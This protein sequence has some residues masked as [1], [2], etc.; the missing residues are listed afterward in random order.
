MK[1]AMVSSECVPFAKTGGLADVVG[2]L[3][4]ALRALGHETLV[5]LPRYADIDGG[6]FG[7][8]PYLAP[9]GVWM[10]DGEEWCAVQAATWEGVPFYFI[11]CD[12]Y[13]AR[14]GLYYDLDFHDY[15]D[16]GRRFGFFTRAALQLC[17]D[18]GFA[19]DVVHAHD[20]QTALAPA[21]LKIWHWDD[22]LLGRA[23]SVLTVHNIAHQGKVDAEAYGHLG[24]QAAN[25][26][27]DKFE[28]H[29]RINFLKGGLHYADVANTVS[30]THAVETRGPLGGH[31]LA[32]FLNDLGDRYVGILNGVDYGEWDPAA[33]PRIPARY[34]RDDPAGKAAC[35]S[36]LQR[37]LGLDEDPTV[38]LVGSVGRFADQK[39]MDVVAA[40]IE[41][42][43]RAMRVQYVVL[44]SGEKGLE[45]FY[46]TL[47]GRHPGRIASWIGYH[48]ELAHWIEAG[49]DFFLM[50]SRFEPCGLNQI[51]SLRYGTLPIVRATGGLNDTV[52]QYDEATGA[53]T[54]FKFDLLT[55][56][57]V[58]DVLGWAVSTFY[59]RPRHV[60]R[61]VRE[62]MARDFSWAKSAREYASLY[63]RAIEHQRR[64]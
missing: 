48:D 35:K 36:A 6:R 26:T 51:Y 2:G 13:F 8:V 29:G 57:A 10:G 5:V 1:V 56:R 61:M 40:A 28:D 24:L 18:L 34:T 47:P 54:G 62:A 25:F 14:P 30:P 19:P 64:L 32:P 27:P 38:P 15:G 23:A 39:G 12:K 49:A 11:E 44:G 16:N 43:V 46:G 60:E 3:A 21:F 7:L 50:P 33:D 52:E 4:K 45:H 31:G 59:D 37:R 63:A 58:S 22:P 42:V 55:P 41:D 9:L 17:K 53:G 20:W